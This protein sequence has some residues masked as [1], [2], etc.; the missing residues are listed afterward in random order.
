ARF[1]TRLPTKSTASTEHASK[2]VAETSS[3]SARVLRLFKIK[4]RKIKRHALATIEPTATE[5]ATP[6][7]LSAS[8][9]I[10]VSRRL[11]DVVRIKSDLVVDLPLL[12]VAQ[13]IVGFRDFF[14]LLLRLLVIR[15]HI[16]MVF[17]RKFAERLPN[18]LGRRRFLHTQNPVIILLISRRHSLF[19]YSVLRNSRQRVPQSSPQLARLGCTPP[20]PTTVSFNL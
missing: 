2:D 13:N 5:S 18:I 12:R 4:I 15:I 19:S 6:A 1:R 14:E 17:A 3:A 9:R 10:R 16:R 7:W 20:N 11:I 8:A